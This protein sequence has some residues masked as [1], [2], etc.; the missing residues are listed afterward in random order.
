MKRKKASPPARTLEA[1]I[2]VASQHAERG[3]LADAEARYREAL[4]IAP[5]HLGVLTLLGLLLVDSEDIDGA[6]DLLERARVVAPG[7]A[8]V[9]LALGSAYAAA[10]HD[11]LAVAAMEVA[12][13]LDTTSTVPLERLARHHIV[14]RRPREAVGLLR[15]ILRRDPTHAHAKFLLAGLTGDRSKDAI[16]ETPTAENREQIDRAEEARGTAKI[17]ESPPPA[18]IADLFDTY[19]AR[20]DQHLV[21][22][23]QYGV[24]KSLAALVATAGAMPDRSW[25]VLDLGCGTGLAGIE[26]RAYAR[27]LIGSD[28]SPRMVARARQRAIY[29]ELHVED[30]A[31]TLARERDIDLIVAADV[32]IYV[33]PLDATIAAC[34]T[35]LRPGGLLAFSVERSVADDVVL[36]QTLRY[37]HADS[38]IL[39]LASTQGL[40]VEHAEPTILRVDNGAP[41]AGVLYVLRR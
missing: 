27:T 24:P 28:L 3:E 40:A 31:V 13:K 23:L 29:D 4:A 10:G 2:E 38:Y 18:L 35:A 22:E 16:V 15:R 32:F 14:A 5:D 20:F 12:I 41:V 34:T 33:G 9:Q 21:E 17:V 6:I 1:L 7:F 30:L 11:G 37:A 8:P 25:R 19:A 26:L 39:S 36:Q